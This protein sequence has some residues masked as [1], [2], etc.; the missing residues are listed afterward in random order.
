MCII[1]SHDMVIKVASSETFRDSKD[2]LN[3]ATVEP[4]QVMILGRRTH[5]KDGPNRDGPYYNAFV[6]GLIVEQVSPESASW[7]PCLRDHQD[8]DLAIVPG[9]VYRR[10]GLISFYGGPDEGGAEEGYQIYKVLDRC[11]RRAIVLA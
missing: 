7:L 10:I 9:N 1:D 11:P 4:H 8:Q 6:E 2:H 5:G 3:K